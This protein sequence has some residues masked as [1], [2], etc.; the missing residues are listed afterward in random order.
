MFAISAD[1][2]VLIATVVAAAKALATAAAAT[3]L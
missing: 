1:A 3:L 2:E